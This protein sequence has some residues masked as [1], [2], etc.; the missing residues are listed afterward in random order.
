MLPGMPDYRI[1]FTVNT[2]DNLA[3]NAATNTWHIGATTDADAETGAEAIR[4]FYQTIDAQMSSLIKTTGGLTWKAYDLTDTE[5]RAPVFEGVA[6]LT[7]GTGDPLPPELSI[8]LSFQAVRL[9]GTPQARR[10][11]RVFLPFLREAVNAADGRPDSSIVASIATAADTLYDTSAA[12]SDWIWE[13][14]S[15]FSGTV[16]GIDNGWVDNEWDIQ[17]RRGRPATSRSVFPP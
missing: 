5:P 3:A 6:D 9:S 8:V 4:D 15:P 10:R 14:F 2:A 7:P 12:A 1:Q 11:N 16:W 17:R 13:G